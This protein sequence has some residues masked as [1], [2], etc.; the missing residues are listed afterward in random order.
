[1]VDENGDV[2][3]ILVKS[4]RDE[5]T[6]KRFLRKLLKRWGRPRVMVTDK[7]PSYGAAKAE[8]APGPEHTASTRH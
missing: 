1:M 4:R 2:L 6:A 5:A 3:D 8:I 7:L